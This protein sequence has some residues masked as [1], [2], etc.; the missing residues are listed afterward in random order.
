[1]KFGTDIK[2]IYYKKDVYLCLEMTDHAFRKK[3]D[4]KNDVERRINETCMS[5]YAV[6]IFFYSSL[7]S[8]HVMFLNYSLT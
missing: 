4:V 6:R 1:M 3:N 8:G 5:G 2:H 7:N